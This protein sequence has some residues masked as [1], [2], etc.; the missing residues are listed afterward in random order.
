M[1]TLEQMIANNKIKTFLNNANDQLNLIINNKLDTNS[2]EFINYKLN[3][4]LE[5]YL[6][7]SVI[8]ED[9]IVFDRYLKNI[10][11]SEFEKIINDVNFMQLIN[12]TVFKDIE[13]LDSVNT[14]NESK[15]GYTGYDVANQDGNY[16]T[17]KNTGKVSGGNRLQVLEYIR[18]VSVNLC[19]SISN[20][21]VFNTLR[22]IY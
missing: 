15:V 20:K 13:N 12:S 18:T 11:V 14:T 10:I 4:L 19:V 1:K 3:A 21:I 5:P 16:A 8:E 17:S 9:P 2:I 22:L 7:V 6:T